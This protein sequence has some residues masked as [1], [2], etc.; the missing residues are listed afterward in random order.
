MHIAYEQTA[1]ININKLNN[2]S[3]VTVLSW[4]KHS[5]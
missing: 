3:V 1:I 2:T 4:D 5:I